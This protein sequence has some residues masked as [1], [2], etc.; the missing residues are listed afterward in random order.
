[1]DISWR[2]VD[3]INENLNEETV[4]LGDNEGENDDG[5]DYIGM[6]NDALGLMDTNIDMGLGESTNY[7]NNDLPDGDGDKFDDLFVAATQEL[8]T[9][10]TKFLVLNFIVKLMHIKDPRNVRLGLSTDGFNSFGNISNAYNMWLVVLVPY[11][12][13]PW[14]CM[15]TPFLMM[16]LLIPGPQ[17]LGKDIDVYLRP[18][19][20]ELKDLWDHGDD[21]YG[22]CGGKTFYMDD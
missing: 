20:D 4:D 18:L 1:M 10:C 21:T 12:L 8:Y 6:L 17:A 7:S 16:S 5:D 2:K 14:K 9:G 11:N 13:P 15:K 19:I 22:V 3:H